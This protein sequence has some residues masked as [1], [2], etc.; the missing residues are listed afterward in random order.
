MDGWIHVTLLSVIGTGERGAASSEEEARCIR[1]QR[2]VGISAG[3]FTLV[4]TLG[5]THK[6]ETRT[7]LAVS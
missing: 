6:S 5:S 7:S 2:L 1:D 4:S 3:K